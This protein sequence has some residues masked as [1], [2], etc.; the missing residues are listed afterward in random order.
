MN[1]Y[2]GNLSRKVTDESL[3]NAFE[4]FG[5]VKEVKIIRDKFTNETKGYA[6]VTMS[7]D[8]EAKQAM[9]QLNN[10]ELDGQ[11]LRVNEALPQQDRRDRGPRS[12]GG[13][14]GGG[15]RSGG[16]GGGPRSGGFGGGPRSG[17]FGGS[18]DRGGRSSGGWRGA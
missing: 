9:E 14:F 1:I 15:P 4:Q 6:F 3:R 13:G 5:E 17:G 18:S 8:D 16:F 7:N 11:R 10:Q 12:S 2:V